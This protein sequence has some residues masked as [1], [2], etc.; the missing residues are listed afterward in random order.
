MSAAGGKS[1][2]PV[3][4]AGPRA[5]NCH[6]EWHIALT[7]ARLSNPASPEYRDFMVSIW[8]E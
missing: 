8:E 1:E 2:R 4:F 5:A 3:E 7:F 6:V